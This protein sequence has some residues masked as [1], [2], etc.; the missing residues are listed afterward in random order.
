MI[1]KYGLAVIACTAL[2][3]GCAAMPEA[4]A[5]SDRIDGAAGE[6]TVVRSGSHTVRIA[7]GTEKVDSL[8]VV[9][10]RSGDGY[11]IV[12]I[13][14]TRPAIGRNSGKE[15]LAFD[16]D[17]GVVQPSFT[18][19]QAVKDK[20]GTFSCQ[21]SVWDSSKVY[22]PCMSGFVKTV[23]LKLA[24]NALAGVITLGAT[25]VTANRMWEARVDPALVQRVVA[26]PGFMDRVA[27]EGGQLVRRRW[28]A[29]YR[30]EFEALRTAAAATGFVGR[31]GSDDPDGL[32]PRAK[33]KWRLFTYRE[34]FADARSVQALQAF[35]A[36][37]RAWDPEALVRKAR[38]KQDEM[39][40]EERRKEADRRAARAEQERVAAFKQRVRP[41]IQSHCGRIVALQAGVATVQAQDGSYARTAAVELLPPGYPC[42]LATHTRPPAQ[43]ECR[44][45]TEI[46]R[47]PHNENVCDYNTYGPVNCRNITIRYDEVRVD[48]RVCN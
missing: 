27:S 45:V 26:S 13:T 22:S 43:A 6:S 7:D 30:S 44:V 19:L 12:E 31:Y 35:I 10:E 18:R 23:D 1:G 9:L 41:G 11:R 14:D 24:N 25:V 38:A 20:P 28:L 37:H 29:G 48:R 17:L 3:A 46:E 33:D 47:F 34:D 8:F 16:A 15:L 32:V 39:R 21:T 42:T 36:K 5:R 2:L 4:P 40:A